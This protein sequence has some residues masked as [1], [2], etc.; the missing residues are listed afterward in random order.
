MLDLVIALHIA[1]NDGVVAVS[2]A[3]AGVLAPAFIAV[4]EQPR[5]E[6]QMKRAM[7]YTGAALIGI[8]T[9]IGN[10]ILNDF[11]V[12]FANAVTVVMAVVGASQMAYGLIWK[13]TGAADAIEQATSPKPPPLTPVSEPEPEE[14]VQPH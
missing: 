3:V 11:E 5:W 13:P 14:P 8:L 1:M 9:V 10:G 4:I 12:T 2:A 7:A 6:P